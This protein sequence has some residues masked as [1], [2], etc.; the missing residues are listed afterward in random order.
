VSVV[1]SWK[2][3]DLS[4]NALYGVFPD[5]FGGMMM[6]RLL[7]L[8]RNELTGDIPVSFADNDALELM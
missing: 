3:R 2:N 4:R 5:W 8:E 7:N 6:L 1:L